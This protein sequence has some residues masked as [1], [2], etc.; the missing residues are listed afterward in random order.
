MEFKKAHGKENAA[1][2][3]T[4]A[5]RWEDIETKTRMLDNEIFE[6]KSQFDGDKADRRLR[7]EVALLAQQIKKEENINEVNV[8]RRYD[9]NTR[10][11]KTT[12][13]GGPHWNQVLARVAVDDDTGELLLRER[14][15]DIRRDSEHKLL[16]G[17]ARNVATALIYRP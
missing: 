7:T 17:D 3:F 16:T 14:A 8:W 15:R 11:A 1:D 9:L 5:L 13:R 2:L 10:N 6:Y 4:K 12:M